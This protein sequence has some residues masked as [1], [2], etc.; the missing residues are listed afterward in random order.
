[1][2]AGFSDR[3]F[4]SYAPQKWRSNAF[5][6]DRQEVK[7]KLLAL[8]RQAAA[9]LIGS[10]GA[11]L[12][13]EASA[14]HPA[15]WNHHQVSAQHVYFSRNEGARKEIDGIIDRARP[16]AALLD[17]PSPQHSHLF[18]AVSV[19]QGA[20]EI[21]LKLHPDARVDRQ[22]LE[23]KCE[24]YFEREKLLGLL[25]ALPAGFQL[26]RMPTDPTARDADLTPVEGLDD[27]RLQ[28]VIAT[29]AAGAA[30]FYVGLRIPRGDERLG[31]AFAE[32]ARAS[33]EGLLPVYH[34]VAWTRDNDF[35]S[36][37]DV[38]KQEKQARRQK[39]LAPKDRVRVV[40]GVF[41]GKA[42]VVQEIDAKGV[43]K[44][45]IGKMAVK[46]EAEDLVKA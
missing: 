27:A 9:G 25:K 6:R 11:P 21:S 23:R 31:A 4:D 46:V 3:D 5:T 18:L 43:A 34:F 45:L 8:G 41:A 16:I 40:R 17:D 42:G 35:V 7:Q 24:D 38:L 33:L 26:G 28:D 12:L 13:V 15:L 44:I 19:W 29:T 10:D 22:N 2:F 39:H 37:R 14:E 32:V 20:A 30:W 36:I 1:M